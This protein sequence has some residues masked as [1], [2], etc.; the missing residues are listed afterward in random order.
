MKASKGLANPEI[1]NRVLMKK[2]LEAEKAAEPL[3]K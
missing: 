3:D 2:L 1:T